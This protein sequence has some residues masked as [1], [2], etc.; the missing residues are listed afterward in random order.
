M[1]FNGLYF[2]AS[3]LPRR[4]FGDIC[5]RRGYFLSPGFGRCDVPIF[6]AT[7]R[8]TCFLT[9]STLSFA[10]AA[11]DFVGLK[12]SPSTRGSRVR[13]A[14]AK[15]NVSLGIKA[16]ATPSTKAE[17]PKRSKVEIIKAGRGERGLWFLVFIEGGRGASRRVAQP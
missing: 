8:P 11:A 9:A 6:N 7:P 13:V 4:V 15:R 5:M 17:E 1:S 16:V 3:R 10:V 12:A 14:V 2:I